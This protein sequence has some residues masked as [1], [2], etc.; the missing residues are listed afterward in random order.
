MRS[1]RIYTKEGGFY[2]HIIIYRVA[3]AVAGYVLTIFFFFVVKGRLDFDLF[4]FQIII[5]SCGFKFRWQN[6]YIRHHFIEEIKF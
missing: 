1:Y 6:W 2:A 5:C 3:W 4:N